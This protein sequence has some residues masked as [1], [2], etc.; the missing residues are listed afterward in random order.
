LLWKNRNDKD[1][2]KDLKEKA[3]KNPFK[4]LFPTVVKNYPEVI[5]IYEHLKHLHFSDKPNYD[6]FQT[7]LT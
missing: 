6:L 3:F 1:E 5:K 4:L 7:V 2:V